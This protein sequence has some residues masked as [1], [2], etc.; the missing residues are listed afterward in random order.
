MA[1]L[2]ETTEHWPSYQYTLKELVTNGY[3]D[4]AEHPDFY[5]EGAD[6]RKSSVLSLTT[7]YLAK[8]ESHTARVRLGVTIEEGG[9]ALGAVVRIGSGKYIYD[10]D[11]LITGHRHNTLVT[12]DEVIRKYNRRMWAFRSPAKPKDRGEV[13]EQEEEATVHRIRPDR[14]S[15]PGL[16]IN[17]VV[18]W[19]REPQT[20]GIAAT[21]VDKYAVLSIDGTRVVL[22][23]NGKLL[24]A[25]ITDRFGLGVGA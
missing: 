18:E 1:R 23:G 13:E 20:E 10:R 3:I 9:K 24:I 6:G 11:L 25:T 22:Q 16:G 7:S 19:T 15:T 12:D 5:V 17:P 21:S 8:P 14:A 4:V 2:I